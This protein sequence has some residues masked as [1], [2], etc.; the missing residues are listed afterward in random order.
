[1]DTIKDN[2]PAPHPSTEDDRPHA[3]NDGK[4]YIGHLVE[5][6]ETG[7]ELEAFEAI[8]CRRCSAGENA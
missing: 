7:E 3:C 8:P 1:M 5:D 6:P 2:A 4:V